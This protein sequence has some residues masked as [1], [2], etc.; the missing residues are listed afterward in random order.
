MIKESIIK[1]DPITFE[2]S[3]GR[4]TIPL[5]IA[6]IDQKCNLNCPGC[7]MRQENK[8]NPNVLMT[9]EDIG[10]IIEVTQPE[11]IDI[12]GGEPTLSPYFKDIIEVC[13]KNETLPWVYSNLTNI[14]ENLAQFLFNR[15]VYVSGKLNIGNP[16]D[17]QQREL[18]AEMIGNKL[19]TVDRLLKG[20]Q[21]MMDAGYKKPMFSIENLLRRKN[22]SFAGEYTRWCL[23]RNIRADVELPACAVPS[24]T[25]IKNAEYYLFEVAPNV[26][27]IKTFVRE[28]EKIY[29][30][31]GIED[32]IRP[33]H[34]S[35]GIC[36]FKNK[37]IYTAL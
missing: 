29:D 9:A 14:D 1:S 28:L 3:Y 10:N 31:F 37:G 26:D 35:G 24:Y 34:V 33:P 18:Q 17:L 12:L 2:T 20:I 15:K 5:V 36:R 11:S 27:Q 30:E 6:E 7:Y 32:K 8:Q 23:E 19:E 21:T 13:I 4:Q 22:I 16:N 25:D